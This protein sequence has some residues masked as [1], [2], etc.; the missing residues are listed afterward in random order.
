MK[1]NFD[2]PPDNTADLTVPKVLSVPP[3]KVTALTSGPPKKPNEGL[4]VLDASALPELIAQ[5]VTVQPL[6]DV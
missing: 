2:K 3:F 5:P 6:V 4:A 1:L